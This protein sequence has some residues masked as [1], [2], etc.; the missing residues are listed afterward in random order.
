MLPFCERTLYI[1]R[2]TYLPSRNRG[3]PVPRNPTTLGGH[4]RRRRLQLHLTQRET[5]IKLEVTTVTMSTW[6]RDLKYP[7][8]ENQPRITAYL[9]YDPFDDPTLGRPLGN[10]FNGVAFLIREVPKT[11]SE[12]VQ[13]RRLELRKNKGEFAKILG[14]DPKTL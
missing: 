5:A 9:G 2:D 12:M 3:I 8:W 10:E 13:K 1:S 11:S 4:L 14:V 7:A 6:E